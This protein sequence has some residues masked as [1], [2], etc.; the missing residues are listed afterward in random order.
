MKNIAFLLVFLGL[1][2]CVAAQI[3]A[4]EFRPYEEWDTLLTRSARA[5][6]HTYQRVGTAAFLDTALHY[7]EL[8]ADMS[9][10]MNNGADFGVCPDFKRPVLPLTQIQAQLDA[11]TAIVYFLPN[12][13]VLAITGD[14]LWAAYGV[15]N[16][17]AW[18]WG[19]AMEEFLHSP[20]KDAHLL[21]PQKKA[22][23]HAAHQMYLAL[24]SVLGVLAESGKKHLVFAR[25]G[26]LWQM[27]FELL[28][29]TPAD[30]TTPFREM[31][32][33]LRHFSV[34]YAPTLFLWQ[35]APQQAQNGRVLFVAPDYAPTA[36]TRRRAR[37]VN[38]RGRL[39]ALDFFRTQAR[40]LAA[41][42][43][44]DTL[45]GAA[46][47]REAVLKHW[48]NT[49]YSVAQLATHNVLH[50]YHRDSAA[51]VFAE[52]ADTITDDI[53]PHQEL[54]QLNLSTALVLL[55]GCEV[56]HQGAGYSDNMPPLAYQTL[57]AG[58]RCVVANRWLAEEAASAPILLQ[59][60]AQLY[61][62]VPPAQALRRAQLFYLRYASEGATHPYFWANY[63][64]FG[65]GQQPIYLQV[66]RIDATIWL[67][68]A[69]R[70]LTAFFL[71][72]L[73]R[74]IDEIQRRRIAEAENL[75]KKV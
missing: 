67:F 44:S 33:L 75:Y 16:D 31:D 63:N 36:A 69:V 26:R 57:Y 9:W 70:L 73:L 62:G 25:L 19:D 12:G 14:S 72:R 48:E 61:N 7:C 51:M 55:A 15:L 58:A 11:Q 52:S 22:F 35:R 38:L 3:F 45:F 42:Y 24:E 53:L 4:P 5:Y 20:Q 37:E 65:N 13:D 56:E 1:S 47:S 2:P 49:P 40:Q 29:C 23:I 50:T 27:P 59:F 10:R 28:L 71:P 68:L 34:T 66:R 74:D 46:A 60:Y 18:Q 30:A 43:A 6:W 54:S 64:C 17:A 21:Q 41:Q 39:R 8:E 32:F